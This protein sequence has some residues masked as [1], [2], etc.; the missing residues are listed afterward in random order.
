MKATTYIESIHFDSNDEYTVEVDCI[1]V[2]ILSNASDL[3]HL[4]KSK[5]WCFIYF[6][7]NQIILDNEPHICMHT[8]THSKEYTIIDHNLNQMQVQ[9][10][11][12][13]L[14]KLS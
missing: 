13:S 3:Y 5:Y 8:F 11:K 12:K 1:E 2:E 7:G 9:M 10:I 14:V 4:I 6:Q